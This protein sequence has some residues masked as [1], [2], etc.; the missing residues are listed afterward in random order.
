MIKFSS[1]KEDIN[2]KAI[3]LTLFETKTTLIL[4]LISFVFTIYF[5]LVGFLSDSEALIYG[6]SALVIFVIL[7]IYLVRFYFL[8]KKSLIQKFNQITKN[9]IINYSLDKNDN[10]FKFIC[11][12]NNQTLEF[13]KEDVKKIKIMKNLII[14]KLNSNEI[15]MLPN[16][17]EI[18]DYIYQKKG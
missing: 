17:K 2:E 18:S 6:Y 14:L 12:E 1:K 13:K 8:C 16:Q 3:K 11:Y 9:D 4:L 15:I 5:L 7:L 10:Y